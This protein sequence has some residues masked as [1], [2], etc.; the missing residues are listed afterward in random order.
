MVEEVEATREFLMR[1]RI[2]DS[3]PVQGSFR[4]YKQIQKNNCQDQGQGEDC[5]EEHQN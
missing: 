1:D 3:T 5:Q 4:G 2:K